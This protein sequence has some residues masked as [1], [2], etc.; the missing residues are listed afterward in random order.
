M[1]KLTDTVLSADRS[2][3][4]VRPEPAVRVLA[5]STTLL[6]PWNNLVALTSTALIMLFEF[7]FKFPES[8]ILNLSV[9]EPPPVLVK[10]VNSPA[11]LPLV[12]VV[13]LAAIKE[14]FSMLPR[15][16]SLLK[17]M[18]EAMLAVP[19]V[20]LEMKWSN[21]NTSVNAPML[22]SLVAISSYVNG[23]DTPIP[24]R[25]AAVSLYR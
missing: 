6:L 10:N 9:N 25:A 24:T 1:P 18:P 3:P 22:V 15:A 8:V 11:S 21:V 14:T 4:P 13:M 12:A 17:R 2:P 7:K 20:A 16:S 19:L 5:V 23:V